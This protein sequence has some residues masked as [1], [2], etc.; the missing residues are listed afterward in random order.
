MFDRNDLKYY[1]K[2][3]RKIDVLT[4][5]LEKSI[6]ERVRAGLVDENE[7]K[8]INELLVK[9][10]LRLVV[11]LAKK[12]QNQGLAFGD[13]ISEG[14]YGL[15]KA[16]ET[17]DWNRG[18]RFGSYAVWW[19]RQS[20]MQALND[21][22]RT[23]RLPVNIIQE[24]RKSEREGILD[25]KLASVP[26]VTNIDGYIGNDGMTLMDVLVNYDAGSP[27]D[28]FNTDSIVKQMM[29]DKMN[30]LEDREQIIIREYYGLLD[31]PKTLDEIG[32]MVGL[33]KE[34]VRQIKEIALRKLRNVSFD[35]FEYF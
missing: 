27:D 13:L 2:D 12:Y 25:D 3:L 28:G 14:N 24:K 16:T 21:H 9:G 26:T 32:T 29:L 1:F 7:K 18:I 15:I 23:I 6:S 11:R 35:M 8:L 5:E 34:R 19:I 20:I 4:P 30:V 10:N 22:A 31:I 17:F 33:T